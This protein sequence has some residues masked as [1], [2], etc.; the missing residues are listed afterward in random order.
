VPYKNRQEE[1]RLATWAQWHRHTLSPES[2]L[3][4]ALLV[5]KLVPEQ[6][7]VIDAR[8]AVGG[9]DKEEAN[10]RSD[11]RQLIPQRGCR[12]GRS[13]LRLE[14]QGRAYAGAVSDW[15][16]RLSDADEDTGRARWS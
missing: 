3:A 14:R 8:R 7:D 9:A 15:L 6:T 13:K 16:R 11:I 10:S 1:L 4:A 12:P 5:V 2:L